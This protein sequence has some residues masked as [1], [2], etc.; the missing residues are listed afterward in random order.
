MDRARFRVRWR[1]LQDGELNCSERPA[2]SGRWSRRSARPCLSISCVR[3]YAFAPGWPAAWRTASCLAIR[4][5]G[6]VVGFSPEAAD[7][8][9]R[10]LRDSLYFTSAVVKRA[11]QR[12]SIQ[13]QTGPIRNLCG[14]FCA[15]NSWPANR[16]CGPIVVIKSVM[17]SPS[18]STAASLA[19][20]GDMGNGQMPRPQ[21]ARK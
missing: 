5:W 21:I 4:I 3:D 1:S 20:R 9:G 14:I 19:V 18:N 12:N 16:A 11:P 7:P 6:C 2:L 17:D 10:F 13:Q 8:P 15:V